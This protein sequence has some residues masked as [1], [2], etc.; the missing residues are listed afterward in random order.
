[1]SSPRTATVS[2]KTNETDIRL[3]L[4]IDGK[5]EARLETGL[6]FFE[7]M[8][9]SLAKHARFDLEVFCKGDLQIDEHHSLEDIGIV[10]GSALAEAVGDKSGIARFGHALV[11]LD[12]A[13]SRA[14]VDFSGRSF[15]HFKAR[16]RRSKVGEMSTEMVEEFWRAF[17][18]NAGITLHLEVL[19]G[20]NTHHQVESL[21][22][23]AARALHEATRF[24]PGVEGVP[25]TKGVL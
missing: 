18:A 20:K 9:G 17:A 24:A 7:H 12:E 4:N 5:G 25:S 3:S 16:F 2:R 10:L 21:F 22:K 15:L 19:Y 8:L 11:P 13:L 1:M 6:G 14:V 23:S